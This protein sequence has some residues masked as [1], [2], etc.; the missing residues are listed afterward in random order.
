MIATYIFLLF[1]NMSFSGMAQHKITTYDDMGTVEAYQPQKEIKVEI[2][3]TDLFITTFE[4]EHFV[5]D[6]ITLYGGVCLDVHFTQE[7]EYRN[8]IICEDFLN[9]YLEKFGE[10]H[11]FVLLIDQKIF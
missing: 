2:N 7:K 10:K 4:R 9:F 11:S 6:S 8:I 1:M 5:I 3:K